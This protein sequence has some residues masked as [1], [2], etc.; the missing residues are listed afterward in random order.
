MPPSFPPIVRGFPH[1]LHGGD[2]NPEQWRYTSGVWEEDFRLLQHAACNTITLG[3]FA[4]SALEPAEGE[5]DF[6]W[7]DAI[8]DKCL[9]DGV[10]VVLATPGGG[11]PAWLAQKYPEVLRVESNGI[12]NRWGG[13]HNHC[14][15][16][17]VYRQKCQIINSKLAER[18]GQHPML[19]LWH[20]NNEYGGECQCHLCTTA[21]RQFLRRRYRDDLDALN[22]AW[23]SSFWSH[24]ISDWSQI[25][26]PAPAA[27]GHRDQS[28]VLDWKRFITHQTIDCFHA[29]CEPLR[30]L[31]PNVP[32]TTN[33]ML[34]GFTEV[35]YYAL[36]DACD[37]VS[38]DSY[39]SYHN[40]PGDYYG[41]LGPAWISFI[42]SQRRA[43]KHKPFLLMECSPG[44]QN[45]K[46]VCKLK[47]PGVH[48]LE[49]L[50]A[51]AHGSDS[52][53][54]FQ[55]RK[56]LG[57]GEK[58]HGAVVDHFPSE[59]ARTFNE[60]AELGR[61]L[62]GLDDVVGTSSRADVA[63]IY[64]YEN[65]C[66]LAET[67]GPVNGKKDKDY[68]PVV[69]EH[70]RPFWSAGV[71]VDVISM[72]RTFDGYKLVVAPMLYMIRPGVA[73]R[74][75][76]FVA[77]GGTLV[78]TFFSGVVNEAD[79][80]FTSG[81]PGPLR[82]LMGVWAEE[83]DALYD[84]E[85]VTVRAAGGN[86]SGLSGDYAGGFLCDLLHAEA[87]QVLATY[88]SEFYA[89]RPAVTM[90]S[91]GRGRAYY[92]ATR[93][94]ARFN[95]DFYNHLVRELALPR[96]LDATLPDGVTAITRGHL[97]F[98][99]SFRPDGCAIDLGSRA[100]VDRLSKRRVSGPLQLPPY[101][102]MILEPA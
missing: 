97:V 23:Y 14:F 54:Y 28:L 18:Y 69:R 3:V 102:A 12:R 60:V 92:V 70:Y 81:C 20:V 50:Q 36:A 89:G 7:M 57:G 25:D 87:A 2:Y 67:L 24:T 83:I 44:A 82:K 35:D 16:S 38:W 49:G 95:A 63:F 37:V 47:R 46:P 72:D 32:I 6:G 48:K 84:D 85:S 80:C 56:S 88:A 101:A 26:P 75:E 34:G 42:H 41:G 66:A 22:R 77:A 9:S 78:T 53:Q 76:R 15:T 65:R 45:Y 5:F 99:L 1:L 4:W 33:L 11:K 21:F 68:D 30:R 73:D 93:G 61:I 64:D 91:F 74:L 71:N 29:E 59:Q 39:P 98:L 94:D 19:A 27:N 58:F 96:A 40:R 100:Y 55:W 79:V 43:M 52:V 62:R 51:I 31:T 90:N 17:P 10:R 13:R 86:P 8:F